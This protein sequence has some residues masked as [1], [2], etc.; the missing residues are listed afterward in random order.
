M[1]SPNDNGKTLF[2][3]VVLLHIR[4][5]LC[6]IIGLFWFISSTVKLVWKRKKPVLLS[7]V[8]RNVLLHNLRS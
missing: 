1:V 4:C 7:A 6:F 5:D 8:H 3:V 2:S